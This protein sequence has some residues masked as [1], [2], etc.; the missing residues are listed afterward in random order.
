MTSRDIVLGITI[1]LHPSRMEFVPD[2]VAACAPIVPQIAVDPDPRGLRSAL[3]TAKVAWATI[4]P[5]ATHHLVL[6]DDVVLAPDFAARVTA[7]IQARPED[8]LTL[9]CNWN[10]PQNSY[11][12]RRAAVCGAAFAPLSPVEWIPT[13][14]LVVPVA[15][16][17][18]LAA[19]LAPIPDEIADDDQMV[20]RYF[21]SIGVRTYATI[22]NLLDHRNAPTLSDHPGTF[23]AT[24]SDWT[25]SAS[26][27]GRGSNRVQAVLADRARLSRASEFGVELK[28]SRCN[29][30]FI[31]PGTPEP[32]AHVFGWYWRD[33]APAAAV[34]P[35][36]IEATWEARGGDAGRVG[37]EVWAAGYLLGVD[38]GRIFL[39]A[40]VPPPDDG[41][42]RW[43][44]A[45]MSSWLGSGLTDR[46]R[47]SADLA[48][49]TVLGAD[50][51]LRGMSDVLLARFNGAFPLEGAR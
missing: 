47:S 13:Q 11:L 9:Y 36:D 44:K 7:A 19:A 45:A 32:I 39:E 41:Q 33:W 23:H 2:L 25:A 38:C 22:P 17:R 8:A 50:A 5:E 15:L 3:R 27:W 46:D 28:Q 16:A 21:E 40:E 48:G 14:G 1:M 51:I 26:R 10:S 30:R 31:R 42:A 37:I 12:V 4:A 20:L 29:L 18:H 24:I 34:R 49:L 35:E 43:A 6:Q